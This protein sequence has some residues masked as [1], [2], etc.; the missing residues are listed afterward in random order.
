MRLSTPPSATGT[1]TA[2]GSAT[3]ADNWVGRTFALEPSLPTSISFGAPSAGFSAGDFLVTTVTARGLGAGASICA[4]SGWTAVPYNGN[5]TGNITSGTI[6]A[7]VTEQSFYKFYNSATDTT[8]IT[9][10]F[11]TSAGSCGAA[12]A[13]ASGI[14]VRY[15]GVNT[16]ANAQI[17]PGTSPKFIPSPKT[18]STTALAAPGSSA[19]T[20]QTT[21]NGDQIVW[22]YGTGYTSIAGVTSSSSSDATSS[23]IEDQ[24]QTTAGV[25]PAG[26]ATT[27]SADNWTA[28]SFALEPTPLT[29][30]IVSRPGTP[31]SGDVVVVTVTARATGSGGSGIICAPTTIT[32][33]DGDSWTTISPNGSAAELT[34]GTGSSQITHATFWSVRSTANTETFPFTFH[35]GSCSGSSISDSATAVAADFT[36]VDVVTPGPVDNNGDSAATSTGESVATAYVSKT[37]LKANAVTMDYFNDEVVH[38]WGT[39]ASTLTNTDVVTGTSGTNSSATGFTDSGAVGQSERAAR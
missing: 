24:A 30:L 8:P 14:L 12:G 22:T 2:S 34:A 32:D 4:P 17:D 27:T 13:L 9:F 7:S 28:R 38:T 20:Y 21:V 6:G 37:S 18:G 1:A 5:A 35:T 23:G 29:S 19:P 36:G 39:S 3:A 33:P 26:T 16:T 10:T 11:K 25:I 31:A 15:T